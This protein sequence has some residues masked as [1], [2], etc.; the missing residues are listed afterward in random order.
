M[1]YYPVFLDLRDREVVVVG[2]G[3]VAERKVRALL[4]AGAR[5]RV[6]SRTFVPS[7][8]ALAECGRIAFRAGEF[9]EA[10]LEGAWLIISATDDAEVNRRVA[11]AA[12]RHRRFCNVADA[13]TFCSFL[14][15]AVIRRGAVAIAISTGGQSPALAVH[16][17]QKIAAIIGPEYGALAELLSHM[18]PLVQERIP[19][20]K[21]RAEVFHRLVESEV[22]D[23]LRAG[24]RSAAEAHARALIE[25]WASESSWSED[26]RDIA[27]GGDAL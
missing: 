7:L 26:L 16:L 24:E 11:E 4:E 27:S 10:D 5:V 25:R 8:K 3:T 9:E 22:F 21:W 1:T 2:G 18:R 6:V 19:D 23:L 15:P 20:P 13:P 14:A 12:A 17:K